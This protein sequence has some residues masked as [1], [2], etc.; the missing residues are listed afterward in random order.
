MGE[1]DYDDPGERERER[2]VWV[3]IRMMIMIMQVVVKKERIASEDV[4]DSRSDS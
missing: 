4:Y 1:D 2:E 3:R